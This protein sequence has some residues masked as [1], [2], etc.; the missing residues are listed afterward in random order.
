MSRVRSDGSTALP[1]HVEDA[2]SP[3]AKVHL[4]ATPGGLN[5]G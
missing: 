1:A 2:V 3:I 4:D 5:V